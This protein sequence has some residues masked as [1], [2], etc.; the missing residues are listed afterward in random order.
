MTLRPKFVKD[1]TL[2]AGDS[3]GESSASSE[4]ED[5]DEDEEIEPNNVSSNDS[6]GSWC[7]LM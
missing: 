2:P 1:L 6:K 5:Q 7:Q 3:E 4:E